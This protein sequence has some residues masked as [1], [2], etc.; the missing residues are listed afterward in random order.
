MRRVPLLNSW[1]PPYC[2]FPGESTRESPATD[3]IYIEVDIHCDKKYDSFKI[4][5][6]ANVTSQLYPL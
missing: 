5:V 3:A 4:L 2:G 1:K 6:I